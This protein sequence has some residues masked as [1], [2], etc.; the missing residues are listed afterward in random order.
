MQMS[1]KGSLVKAVSIGIDQEID[2]LDKET[3]RGRYECLSWEAPDHGYL[4]YTNPQ[5][6]KIMRIDQH[7]LFLTCLYFAGH[8]K[9]G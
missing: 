1:V 7:M 2:P 3:Y 9:A 5:A 8:S 6:R 4:D